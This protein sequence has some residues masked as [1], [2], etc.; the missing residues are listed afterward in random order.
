[1][2]L[3][4][5]NI[6]DSKVEAWNSPL[7]YRN[8]GEATRA[9]T[10]AVNDTKCYLNKNPEDYSFFETGEFDDSTGKVISY[11][12]NHTIGTAIQFKKSDGAAPLSLV[13]Q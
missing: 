1:M 2:K 6:Y 4:M 8:R 11:P 9:F 3:K 13:Q 10:E 5:Y 7:F 12:E